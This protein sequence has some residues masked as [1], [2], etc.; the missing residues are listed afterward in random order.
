MATC[1]SKPTDS[2]HDIDVITG[3]L[4]VGRLKPLQKLIPADF[5]WSVRDE[6]KVPLLHYAVVYGLLPEGDA[7]WGE[8]VDV[9]KWMVRSGADPRYRACSDKGDEGASHSLTLRGE[10]IKLHYGDHSAITLTIEWLKELEASKNAADWKD[11]CTYLEKVLS[12]LTESAA[13]SR[14]KVPVDASLLD[15]WESVLDMKDTHNVTFETADGPVTAHDHILM[16]ASPVLKAMLQSTMKEGVNKCVQI[17]DASSSAASLFLEVLYT[18][19]TRQNPDYKAML[20]A[21]ELAHRWQTHGVVETLAAALGRTL[22]PDNFAEIAEV[23]V[24]TGV[25]SLQQS[26]AAF[27]KKNAKMVVA[28]RKKGSLPAAVQRLLG[29]TEA[30]ATNGQ[31]SKKR[32]LL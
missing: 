9:I 26:C 11:Q 12:V 15:M 19:A 30:P 31:S 13:S 1:G 29:H 27:G 5:D 17:P 8:Y 2:E 4:D 16:A 3:L 20:A 23:A 18:R 25:M 21:I 10:K 14:Q 32:R 28:M 6:D 24:L 22:A 7:K